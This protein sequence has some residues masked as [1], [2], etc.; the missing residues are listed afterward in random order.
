MVRLYTPEDYKT[1]CEWAAEYEISP[2]APEDLPHVGVVSEKAMGFLYQTD[3][4]KCYI[5]SFI[6]RRYEHNEE[7]MIEVIEA[8][9]AIAKNLGFKELLGISKFPSLVKIAKQTGYITEPKFTFLRRR[10]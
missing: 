1:V 9:A 8:I 6:A 2:P 4:S 10:L 7:D 3:S 5:E